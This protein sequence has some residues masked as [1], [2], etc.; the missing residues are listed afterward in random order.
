MT[1]IVKKLYL[2]TQSIFVGWFNPVPVLLYI[3]YSKLQKPLL[4][5]ARPFEIFVIIG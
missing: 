4:H 2:Y 5:K 1:Q 3:Y